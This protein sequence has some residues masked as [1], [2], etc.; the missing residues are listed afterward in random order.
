MDFLNFGDCNLDSIDVASRSAFLVKRLRAQ[1]RYAMEYVPFYREKF[2]QR[3]LSPESIESLSDYAGLPVLRKETLRKLG[4]YG[5]LPKWLTQTQ[6]VQGDERVYLNRG[7]GGTTGDP[8]AM[9]WTY[10]DWQANTESILRMM[11]EIT[12]RHPLIAFNGYN[13]GHIAGPAFDAAI[14]MLGG[15]TIPR[16]F[17]A[18]D[19]MAV[20]QLE[21]YRANV[22]IA[23]PQSGSAK[24]G[25]IVDLLNAD[26]NG[27]ICGDNI[28]MI[29]HSST[30]MTDDLLA[31]LDELG[32]HHVV[33]IYGSTDA[34]PTAINCQVDRHSM[35]ITN[36]HIYL[37][38][39]DDSGQ[40]VK[41]GERGHVVVSRI[42]S[43]A[44]SRIDVSKATQLFRY[45]VGDDATFI[46]EPC[47]CGRTTAKIKDIRRVEY[48]EDKLTGG[49]EVW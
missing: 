21:N 27:Y 12:I 6:T 11:S 41:N 15:I 22:L 40:P 10:A 45:L 23:T 16:H 7:T 35:H 37:E 26:T 49:C 24:G 28:F 34:F 33:N 20:R 3:G 2:T 48:L 38:V 46:D 14:R 9:F 18:T 47:K 25:S 13:Q 30:P 8:T 36:G 4:P 5:T 1:I 44:G 29:I 43:S 19:N 39:V 17:N 42:G 31:E 32:I